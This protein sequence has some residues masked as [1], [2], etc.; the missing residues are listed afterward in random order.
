MALD[1]LVISVF[2]RDLRRFVGHDKYT[3]NFQVS[4]PVAAGQKCHKQNERKSLG[5][6]ESTISVANCCCLRFGTLQWTT[7]IGT[8][9]KVGSLANILC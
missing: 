3:N 5:H 6:I 4:R 1:S 9:S 7:F 2:L 8:Q